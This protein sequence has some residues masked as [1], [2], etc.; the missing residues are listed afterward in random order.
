M[1]PDPDRL[2]LQAGMEASGMGYHDLWLRQIAVSGDASELELE[3]YLLGLLTLDP[4]QYNIIAQA[5]NEHFI[6][7][8]ENHPVG[9]WDQARSE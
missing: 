8:G 4:L 3:A 9:Y 2:S 5:I 7:R 1:T 6:D